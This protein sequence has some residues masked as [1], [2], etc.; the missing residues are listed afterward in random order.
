MT[1]VILL[2]Q[3]LTII[4]I[5]TTV[6]AFYDATC[7]AAALNPGDDADDDEPDGAGDWFFNEDEAEQNLLAHGMGRL[8]NGDGMNGE[9]GGSDD[10]DDDEGEDD[11]DADME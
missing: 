9:G 5:A 2:R 3:T 8:T 6:T 4:T 1:F 11:E 10:M 7:D